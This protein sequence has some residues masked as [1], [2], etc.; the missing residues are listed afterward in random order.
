MYIR[1]AIEL[2]HVMQS[3]MFLFQDHILWLILQHS[4]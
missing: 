4:Q 2:F 1:I 3:P